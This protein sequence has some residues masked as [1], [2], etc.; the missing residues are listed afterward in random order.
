MA[1][2]AGASILSLVACSGTT[3][4]PRAGDE[5]PNVLL[6]VADDLAYADLGSYGGDIATPNIDALAARGVRFSQFHTAPMCAPTRAMLLSGNDNHV[7]GMGW[8][9]GGPVE[10]RGRTGYEG[11]LS[12]RIVPFPL[13]LRDA[14]YHTYS[15]GKWHL[16]TA[17]D[18]TPT[19]AGFERSFQ[20]L[21]GAGDHF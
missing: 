18:H 6:I 19:A 13:L 21:Q 3:D 14:G 20:L 16:G 10:L 4:A 11:H 1:F 9:G 17:E 2:V 8:Q 5:P 7:A 12:D 15:V